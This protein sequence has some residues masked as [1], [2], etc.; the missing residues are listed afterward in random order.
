VKI[1]AG[2]SPDKPV[3]L[4]ISR[5]LEDCGIDALTLH[6]RFA[7]QGFSG[8]AEWDLIALVKSRLG[9]PVIGNGDVMSPFLA[10]EM[11]RQTGCDAVMIGRGAVTNPWIFRQILDLDQGAPVREPGI[12]ERRD[13]IME[14][15]RLLCLMEGEEKASR[16]MRGLLCRYTRGLP[17]SG[18][19]RSRFGRILDLT[20]LISAL[21]DFFSLLDSRAEQG[22]SR[23]EAS[24]AHAP[25][26][27]TPRTGDA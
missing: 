14:H 20:S 3:A 17:H 21:D 15:F 26:S 25:C 6:P 9:I 19:F 1:R 7:T 18:Q 23:I 4:E 22:H 24:S 27:I 13:L 10:L 8:K 2:W 12:K 16:A 11:L 5:I